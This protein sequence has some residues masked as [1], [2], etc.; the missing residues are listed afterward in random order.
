[1][2]KNICKIIHAILTVL[3]FVVFSIFP[4]SDICAGETRLTIIHGSNLNGH[5][6]PCPT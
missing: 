4:G 6:V 2:K 1:M 5:L 3:L